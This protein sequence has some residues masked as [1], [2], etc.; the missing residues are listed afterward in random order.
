MAK[1]NDYKGEKGAKWRVS[2][3]CVCVAVS[4]AVCGLT[5][6]CKVYTE[7]REERS[8]SHIKNRKGE[9]G[10][11]IWQNVRAAREEAAF[12]DRKEKRKAGGKKRE[13]RTPKHW[14]QKA[15]AVNTVSH[16]HTVRMW[17]HMSWKGAVFISPC[18]SPSQ[19]TLLL[20]VLEGSCTFSRSSF[21]GVYLQI[22]TRF[23]ILSQQKKI[24]FSRSFCKSAE[25]RLI[26][27]LDFFRQQQV[28]PPNTPSHHTP[29]LSVSATCLMR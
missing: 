10:R 29:C 17:C 13:W 6:K 22:F 23:W 5:S 9:M 2:R 4:V 15:S 24:K 20:Y 27:P 12:K 19:N 25:P 21:S 11:K 16:T 7:M 26:F 3:I 8:G 14:E 1:Q 18:T 28:I